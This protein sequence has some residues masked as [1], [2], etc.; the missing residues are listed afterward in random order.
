MRV[1][2]IGGTG[3][4]GT[5]LTPRLV[6]DGHQVIN[7]SRGRREPYQPNSAW[8]E[9]RRV[10]MDRAAEEAAGTFGPRIRELQADAIVDITCYTPASARH[11]VEALRGSVRHFLHCGTIWVH[12]PIVK[13]P[14]AEDEPRKPFGDYGCRKAEIESYLLAEAQA[15]FPVSVLHPGH[16]VGPGWAPVNPAGNFNPQVFADLAAGR[17]V[18]LPNL[19]NET[20]HHVH[21]DDVAQAFVQALRHWPAAVGESFHVVSPAAL[22]LRDYAE[23][24][25]SWFH[26][27][28]KL[29]LL[30]WEEWR[31]TVSERDA[32]VTGNHIAHSSNCSIEKARRLLEYRPRFSSA[33]AVRE[34][35]SSLIVTGIVMI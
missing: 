6:E 15:G 27:P 18:A 3:H 28:A 26:Q 16:L 22:T 5:Y 17:E 25:A 32:E 9:V 24:V 23:T 33:A 1:I 2:V 11:L 31:Q 10:T 8:R 30:P 4:I 19:G 7:I 13:G 14:I 12:G 29:R 34:A 20:L 21:A 35:L